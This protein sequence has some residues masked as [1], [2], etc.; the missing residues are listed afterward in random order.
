MN[1]K[2]ILAGMAVELDVHTAIIELS[3]RRGTQ[4]DCRLKAEGRTEQ[5]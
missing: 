2:L 4:T 3:A 5:F 1:K